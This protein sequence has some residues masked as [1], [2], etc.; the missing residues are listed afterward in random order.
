M[1][2]QE[3]FPQRPNTCP[4]IYAYEDTNPQYKGM[5]KVGYTS[6]DVDKR[7][8]EQYPTKRPDGSVPYKIV[9][10]EN[11]M[12]DD[13]T[14]FK[15][16]DVHKVLER[17]GFVRVGGEWFKCKKEDVLAAIN[18]VRTRSENIENR[19]L[20]FPMRPEQKAAVEKTIAYYKS[21]QKDSSPYLSKHQNG[22][23]Q[24]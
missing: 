8:A 9:V 19:S 22:T 12:Y 16:H 6:I 1:A 24:K 21:A 7:V 2:K 18:A 11:A 4:M 14:G 10:R 3:Y 20:N 15:D 17:K 5:L 13:G 23:H